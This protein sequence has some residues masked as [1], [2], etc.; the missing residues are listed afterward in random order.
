MSLFKRYLSPYCLPVH[1]FFILI[2]P[3]LAL[4]GQP[5]SGQSRS[6]SLAAATVGLPG[7][8]WAGENPA[9]LGSLPQTQISLFTSAG[10]G[11]RDLQVRSVNLGVPY[12]RVVMALN[13]Q[14]FGHKAYQEHLF[15]FALAIPWFFGASRAVWTGAMASWK[16]VTIR[17]YD[18]ASTLSLTFGMLVEP[19]QGLF[20]G[21]SLINAIQLQSFIPLLSSFQTGLSY[22]LQ[23]K[24]WVM[25]ALDL[26][27]RYK[28]SARLGIESYVHPDV[29][30]RMGMR[31]APARITLGIG[32][33][34]GIFGFHLATEKH[35]LLGW[36]P[37]LSVDAS[38]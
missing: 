34:T 25:V 6:A 1:I 22:R 17:D 26:T 24:N 5:L 23:D 9:A 10:Y 15:T 32:I 13:A 36:T 33:T 18:R 21:T 38:L 19:V 30:L 3:S 28:A 14:S 11:L 2:F 7:L 35:M 12:R 29:A 27:S 4:Y 16:Q 8:A 20:W 37:A 31:T